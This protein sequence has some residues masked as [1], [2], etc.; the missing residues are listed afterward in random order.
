MATWRLFNFGQQNQQQTWKDS[1]NSAS[2][3]TV[4]KEIAILLAEI[5]Y[6][7]YLSRQ[8]EERVLLTNS[9]IEL[10]VANMNKPSSNLKQ[11]QQQP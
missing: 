6:Q 7:M 10:L 1:I 5:N 8:Q 4:Q 9:M 3:A 11:Q 2:E